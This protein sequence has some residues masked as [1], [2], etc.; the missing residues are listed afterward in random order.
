MSPTGLQSKEPAKI[1]DQYRP[2]DI[3]KNEICLLSFEETSS[4]PAENAYLHLKLHYVILE[5]RKPDYTW[6]ALGEDNATIYVD[7]MA[8]V[9]SMHL[10]AALQ[11]LQES[12]ECRTRMKVWASIIR[13][14]SCVV[15]GDSDRYAI[16]KAYKDAK[17]SREVNICALPT[18]QFPYDQ[19][20]RDTQVLHIYSDFRG[21]ELEKARNLYDFRCRHHCYYNSEYFSQEL[22]D[23][24]GSSSITTLKSLDENG[25]YLLFPELAEEE[26]RGNW[27]NRVLDL[28]TK[29]E[30]PTTTTKEQVRLAV[31]LATKCFG[32]LDALDMP[33]CLLA[34]QNRELSPDAISVLISSDKLQDV[35]TSLKANA[36]R[37]F[38]L[39]RFALCCRALDMKQLTL[40]PDTR[41]NAESILDVMFGLD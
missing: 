22:I 19:F 34:F 25:L 26:G 2:L 7:G 17:P 20:A 31:C 28:R 13:R 4:E 15:R 40:S 35:Q 1:Q 27:T 14:K 32:H 10:K 3:P 21:T 5:D 39:L 33:L 8:T 12:Y 29:W 23:H 18:D 6:G 38:E 30:V 36:L 16:Y 24:Y 11:D 41:S 9:V 37:P